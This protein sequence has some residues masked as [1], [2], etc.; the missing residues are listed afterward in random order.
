MN[1]AF[2]I[3]VIS[4]DPAEVCTI[5]ETLDH[6]HMA[7]Q[8]LILTSPKEASDYIENRGRIGHTQVPDM[9]LFGQRMWYNHGLDL[10]LAVKEHLRLR[11][12]PIVILR[13]E[14]E[15]S[16]ISGFDIVAHCYFAR[17]DQ[18]SKM[19][20]TIRSFDDFWRSIHPAQNETT[21]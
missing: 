20:S 2:C 21:L 3:A 4:G 11:R 1:D 7:H 17:R 18:L 19:I 9:I 6:D 12:I 10:L 5:M 8:L 14:R 15:A 13:N 16:E